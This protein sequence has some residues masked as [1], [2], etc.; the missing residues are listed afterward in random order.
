MYERAYSTAQSSAQRNVTDLTLGRG[1]DARPGA[2]RFRARK[3]STRPAMCRAESGDSFN[4]DDDDAAAA[5]HAKVDPTAMR[6]LL[7]HKRGL[8]L[9]VVNRY[10]GNTPARDEDDL[11]QLGM[12]GLTRAVHTFDPAKGMFAPHATKLIRQEIFNK[13]V[14]PEKRLV[15]RGVRFLPH[16]T[17]DPG[18]HP[19]DDVEDFS[20]D[21]ELDPFIRARTGSMLKPERLPPT[22]RKA[23]ARRRVVATDLTEKQRAVLLARLDGKLQREL[24]DQRVVAMLEARALKSLHSCK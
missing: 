1:Q 14:R 20:Q 4:V 7:E 8:V 9:A 2:C 16:T 23:E 12:I 15:D 24:G 18:G 13:A 3:K 11:F 17:D 21:F 22:E 10:K 5:A 6:E 19:E